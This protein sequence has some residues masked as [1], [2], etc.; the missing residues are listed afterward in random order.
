MLDDKG[1]FIFNS[2][3]R[4]SVK[5]HSTK[6]MRHVTPYSNIQHAIEKALNN[7]TNNDTNHNDADNSSN[8]NKNTDDN[9]ILAL[10]RGARAPCGRRA[11]S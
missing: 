3:G 5:G 1:D 2:T 8:D 6:Q 7:K 10:G 4:D 11:R 9:V